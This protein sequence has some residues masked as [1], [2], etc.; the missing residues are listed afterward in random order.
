[1]AL[2]VLDLDTVRIAYESDLD[3]NGSLDIYGGGPVQIY[4]IKITNTGGSAAKTFVKLY[5]ALA[6]T[7]G[8]TAPER[9]IHV[10]ANATISRMFNAEASSQGIAFSTG[11]SMA[12][13]SDVD[14]S[15]SGN[16]APAD[17]ITCAILTD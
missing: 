15:G 8:T 7:I 12:A 2:S 14:A 11:L 9:V 4:G 1:M 13:T 5:D 10:P 6:P 17:T 3:E 16:S